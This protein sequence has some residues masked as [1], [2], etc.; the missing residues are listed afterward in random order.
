MERSIVRRIERAPRKQPALGAHGRP[1]P[2]GSLSRH[3]SL[4]AARIVPSFWGV[5]RRWF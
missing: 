1:E 4:D 5:G 3:F 2:Y